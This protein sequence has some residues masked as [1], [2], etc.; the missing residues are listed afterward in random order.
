M[1]EINDFHGENFFL[2]NFFPQS[3]VCEGM[4]WRSA[5]H[6][7]QAAK[8][9][10]KEDMLA[11]KMCATAG[12]AK[13]MGRKIRI[14]YDWDQIKVDVMR[15]ILKAKFGDAELAVKLVGTGDAELIEGNNWCDKTWG[16][17]LENG[18]WEGRNLLGRLLM[19]VRAE[20]SKV[21]NP[22]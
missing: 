9:E 22:K 1:S 19:E 11:V 14:R 20:L 4:T 13:K 18:E 17:V 16:C 12:Q 5:E 21:C 7:Y 15:N 10:S 2:S 8:A 6:A 3:F